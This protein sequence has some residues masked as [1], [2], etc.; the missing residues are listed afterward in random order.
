MIYVVLAAGDST[1]M[2]YPKATTPLGG[3][4]PLSRIC[5][6]L[7]GRVTIVVTQSALRERCIEEAPFARVLVNSRPQDGMTS[8]LLVAE[9]T[10]D[11]GSPIGIVL[12]DQPFLER[13][14]VACCEARFDEGGA[15]VVYPVA[16]DGTPG[17]PVYFGPAARALLRDAA[18][19][20]TLRSVR[21]DPSL[22]RATVTVDDAGAFADLDTPADWRVAEKR[23]RA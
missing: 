8:S 21:D 14:T 9:R 1:R 6:V 13:A 20:D 17:H 16:H 23:V 5:C 2:G 3:R 11:P 12:A 10:I 15:D 18:P 22:R 19:G 4:T 7:D